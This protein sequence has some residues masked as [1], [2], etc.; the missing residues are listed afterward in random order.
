M[1]H[2]ELS[3]L[4]AYWRRWGNESD[5]RTWCN[6]IIATDDGLLKLLPKFLQHTQS[7]VMGD[8]AVRVRPR[9]NPTWLENYFDTTAC[10]ERLSEFT[11]KGVIPDEAK[12]TVSQFL[13][14]FEMLKTG[15]NPD[16]FGV[17]DGDDA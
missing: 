17:F 14:E 9:L 7:Q 12:E 2:P 11:K 10:A 4:L 3:Q 13:K 15:K 6:H 5:V 8:W 16:G 1:D